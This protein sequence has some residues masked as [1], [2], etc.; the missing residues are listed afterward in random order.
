MSWNKEFALCSDSC[1]IKLIHGTSHSPEAKTTTQLFKGMMV[2]IYER[3]PNKK[4]S[5]KVCDYHNENIVWENNLFLCNLN[6]L[7]L[8]SAELWPFLIAISDPQVRYE[9]A[10]DNNWAQ[11]ITRSNLDHIVQVSNQ[12]FAK[13][14]PYTCIIRFIGLVPEIGP[15][16]HFGLEILV[17]KVQKKNIIKTHK[18]QLKRHKKNHVGI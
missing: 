3:L 5:I 10:K 13:E 16:Y 7:L 11:F 9:H 1:N 15:G 6:N 18:T 8:V 17:N 12:E 2:Q 14:F 4:C